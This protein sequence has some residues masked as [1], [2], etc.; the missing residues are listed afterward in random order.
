MKATLTW[1][2]NTAPTSL[3]STPFS[4]SRG[5]VDTEMGSGCSSTFTSAHTALRL[6]SSSAEELRF[7]SEKG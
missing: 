3:V 1:A 7:R 4:C 2:G 6:R 5:S